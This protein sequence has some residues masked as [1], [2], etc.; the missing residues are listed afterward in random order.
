MANSL[1]GSNREFDDWQNSDETFFVE[2][3]IVRRFPELTVKLI[4]RPRQRN[5]VMRLKENLILTISCN[6]TLKEHELLCFFFANEEWLRKQIQRMD[7]VRALNPKKRFSHGES[8]LFLGKILPLRVNASQT[9][10]LP[11]KI[12]ISTSGVE[13]IYIEGPRTLTESQI[14]HLIQK[15]YKRYANRILPQRVQDWSRLTQL[16]P[17]KLVL[18]AQRTRWG[19]CSTSG[20]ISLNWKLMAAPVKVMDYV[21]VHELC[22]L[23][24]PNHSQQFWELVESFCSD[25]QE[26]RAWLREEGRKVDFLSQK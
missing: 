17:K 24:H 18:R 15:E 9:S 16:F 11:A 26:C 23:V 20:L 21:I 4:R 6:Q 22:H 10:N 25:Y 19:S 1:Y 7:L 5:V 2:S 3:E 8:F 14:R 13:E 12:K